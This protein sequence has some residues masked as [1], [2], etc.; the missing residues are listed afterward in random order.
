MAVYR[1]EKGFEVDLI[2]RQ[3]TRVRPIEIKSAMTF[4]GKLTANLQKYTDEDPMAEKP[5]LVYDGEPVGSF[6]PQHVSA[7]NFR[8]FEL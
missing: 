1:T 7:V 5:L 4:N 8:R 3:G 6:G 2:V